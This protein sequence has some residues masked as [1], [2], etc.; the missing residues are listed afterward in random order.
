[1]LDGDEGETETIEG[2]EVAIVQGV[3][4]VDLQRPLSQLTYLSLVTL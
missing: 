3:I 4:L 1:M 2:E